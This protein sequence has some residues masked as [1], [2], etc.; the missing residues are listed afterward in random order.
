VT[1]A[2]LHMSNII[3]QAP[4]NNSAV[5]ED[6]ESHFRS[7]VLS[8][9]NYELLVSSFSHFATNAKNGAGSVPHIGRSAG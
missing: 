8:T 7:L 9:N 4:N 1:G 5:W 3:P 6:F 2:V